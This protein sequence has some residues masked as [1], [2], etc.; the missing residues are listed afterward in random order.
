MQYDFRPDPVQRS[1]T[2]ISTFDYPFSGSFCSRLV[3]ALPYWPTRRY[4]PCK[5]V[6]SKA[7]VTYL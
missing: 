7:R 3:S 5:R 4:G 2:F 1:M 6:T